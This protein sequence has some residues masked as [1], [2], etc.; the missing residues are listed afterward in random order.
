[1][2]RQGFQG[3]DVISKMGNY[4]QGEKER[5]IGIRCLS[6]LNM[7]WLSLKSGV[8]DMLMK[9][10]LCGNRSYMGSMERRRGLEFLQSERRIWGWVMEKYQKG[11]GLVQQ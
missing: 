1:M 3:E 6:S 10:K 8:R 4:F 7:S 11:M 5:G 9:E 2:E